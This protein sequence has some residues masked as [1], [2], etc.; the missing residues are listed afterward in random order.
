MIAAYETL[1]ILVQR[2][3]YEGVYE[4]VC[5]TRF[6]RLSTTLPPPLFDASGR[7]IRE[8][9]SRIQVFARLDDARRAKVR[10]G[11]V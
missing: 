4:R 9:I 6:A 7:A 11:F 2:K 10:W 1:Q 5:N 3:L 8:G